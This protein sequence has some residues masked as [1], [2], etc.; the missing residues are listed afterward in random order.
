M[1]YQ[2]DPRTFAQF[3]QRA[4]E[5]EAEGILRKQQATAGFWDQM[6][7]L[8][9]KAV[10]MMHELEDRRRD[11]EYRKQLELES[12]SRVQDADARRKQ[13]ESERK[14]EEEVGRILE[15][16]TD[17]EGT[18][19]S[20]AALESASQFGW[21]VYT[22]MQEVVAN[23]NSIVAEQQAQKAKEN[24]P[25]I[26]D[27]RIAMSNVQ[28]ESGT[29][30]KTR[31]Y[32]E[33][34]A[35]INAGL[36]AIGKDPLP[37]RLNEVESRDEM[38]NV[39]PRVWD[40]ELE[41][42]RLQLLTGEELAKALEAKN[43][44][45]SLDP[46]DTKAWMDVAQNLLKTAN[47][48]QQAEDLVEA[49]A[50]KN[51]MPAF[52]YTYMGKIIDGYDWNNHSRRNWLTWVDGETPPI[53]EATHFSKE[54]FNDTLN[55]YNWLDNM[56]PS[57][58][59]ALGVPEGGI[60]EQSLEQNKANPMRAFGALTPNAWNHFN[61]WTNSAPP[62]GVA[63]SL[64]DFY[65]QQ[66]SQRPDVDWTRPEVQRKFYEEWAEITGRGGG[67]PSFNP[68][69]WIEF[70]VQGQ[71]DA[72]GKP[73][74]D[75][76]EAWF[77]A[78]PE[79]VQEHLGKYQ[80]LTDRTTRRAGSASFTQRQYFNL[81]AQ[82]QMPDAGVNYDYDKH[83]QTMTPTERL[84]WID[85]AVEEWKKLGE[86]SETE[87]RDAFDNV[88]DA[89]GEDILTAVDLIMADTTDGEGQQGDLT[90]TPIW[91]PPSGESRSA[92]S[93]RS[94]IQ[95]LAVFLESIR[96]QD[97]E[98]SVVGRA[99]DRVAGVKEGPIPD[100]W[101]ELWD[102]ENSSKPGTLSASQ[103]ADHLLEPIMKV[104]NE[105]RLNNG[106]M[107]IK[108]ENRLLQRLVPVLVRNFIEDEENNPEGRPPD[109]H[110]LREALSNPEIYKAHGGEYLD[111]LN[112]EGRFTSEGL[113]RWLPHNP[114][115]RQFFFDEMRANLDIPEADV[116][117]QEKEQR[118][119]DRHFTNEMRGLHRAIDKLGA[120]HPL[121]KELLRKKIFG[122]SMGTRRGVLAGGEVVS[123][124]P[125]G[126]RTW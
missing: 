31:T 108:R 18:L 122:N 69:S 22:K 86:P 19:N 8:P 96:E 93:L 11:E 114:S 54:S 125:L 79:A 49:Y 66:K 68:G 73:K 75:G 101:E 41:D 77:E 2:T 112:I 60:F 35:A 25:L 123:N 7:Q 56:S 34:V 81:L 10:G 72:D 92:A 20:L 46:Q 50:T 32:F 6:S 76:W 13:F 121:I 71:L 1:A 47:D 84:E 51:G 74:Y 103:L 85:A 61:E 28:G 24:Q 48:R 100:N 62:E 3:R 65:K 17:E 82:E 113:A 44:V 5:I 104:Q 42:A 88:S 43:A 57:E 106:G 83:I 27:A 97:Q 59:S 105:A 39:I 63:M 29:A 12:K 116:N 117:R 4:G 80:S 70:G 26:Q 91:S 120:S 111:G 16:H 110:D 64:E 90:G 53:R 30:E 95:E 40:E 15:Q 67:T 99:I 55:I 119:E 37:S 52:A 9:E 38:G 58:R 45:A 14:D 89:L 107:E 23:A 98:K 118:Y 78:E 36:V 87:D 109:F 94:N 21:R 115:L 124:T 33:Q 102:R 126:D